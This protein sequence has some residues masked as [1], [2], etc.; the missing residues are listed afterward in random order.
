M[1]YFTKELSVD[2]DIEIG[3]EAYPGD[4]GD[5]HNPPTEGEVNITSIKL[6]GKGVDLEFSHEFETI[7]ESC[8][9]HLNEEI[10]EDM[11]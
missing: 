2:F 6:I 5:M 9:E 7:I 4:T 11:R 8:W 10:V 3:F 1:R